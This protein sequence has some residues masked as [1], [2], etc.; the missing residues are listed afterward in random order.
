VATGEHCHIL[1]VQHSL[2]FVQSSRDVVP[3]VGQCIN[4][5]LTISKRLQET[6]LL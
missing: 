2:Y 1:A 5:L 4:V 6:S 3:Y